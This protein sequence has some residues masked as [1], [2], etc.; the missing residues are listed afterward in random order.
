ML[1]SERKL[2]QLLAR[3]HPEEQELPAVVDEWIELGEVELD[4][5]V[6]GV[7]AIPTTEPI[8]R[9]AIIQV[10]GGLGSKAKA[11]IPFLVAR[12]RDGGEDEHVRSWAANSLGQMQTESHAA[13]MELCKDADPLVRYRAA[14]ELGN[15]GI[16]A[17]AVMETLLNTLAD[18]VAN[19]R[20]SA[21]GSLSRKWDCDLAPHLSTALKH[22]SSSV[23][24]A[25]AQ[26]LLTANPKDWAA[27]QRLV[28][29]LREGPAE[30]RV[31]ACEALALAKEAGVMALEELRACLRHENPAVRAKAAWALSQLQL[32]ALPALADLGQALHDDSHDVRFWAAH[33]LMRLDELAEPVTADLVR[34]LDARTR[35]GRCPD[36]AECF[37]LTCLVRTVGNVG[38]AASGALPALK[39]AQKE[40]A[41]IA[42]DGLK[43]LIRWS[44][45][46]CQGRA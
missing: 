23:R 11:A 24:V 28:D 29:V 16:Y 39:L 22:P 37:L 15:I 35:T 2:Q 42:D 32:L 36:D 31:W 9:E 13:L 3:L 45:R 6:A 7:L 25:V 20:D 41:H 34:A 17:P 10:L 27:L 40:A 19:V 44:I 30:A 8:G 26:T 1:M 21:R 14:D 33:A 5:I 12:L 46:R 4:R 18:P 38:R 43:N